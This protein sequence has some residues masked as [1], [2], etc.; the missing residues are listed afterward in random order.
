MRPFVGTVPGGSVLGKVVCRDGIERLSTERATRVGTNCR[1]RA[2][3]SDDSDHGVLLRGD[4]FA[5]RSVPC[6][7]RVN[8]PMMHA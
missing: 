6:H 4:S 3:P 2:V 5:C 8:H 7:L 1:V